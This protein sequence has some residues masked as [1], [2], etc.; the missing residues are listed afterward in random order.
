MTKKIALIFAVLLV[1]SLAACGGGAPDVD[2]QL[3]V[4]GAV[5][6]P[7]TLSY[8]ELAKMPQVDLKDI[9]MEKSTGEDVVTSWT[10]VSLDELLNKAGAT[11][12]YASITATASDGYAIEIS[13]DEVQDA[14]VALKDGSEWIATADAEHGPI[15]LVCPYTPGNRWVF[16]LQ[17][18]QVNE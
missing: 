7:L 18:I 4:S 15:R 13:R 12:G 5:T 2:W 9:L 17:E 10:G 8:S 6:N 11:A 3:K 16:Q 1:L 14:I